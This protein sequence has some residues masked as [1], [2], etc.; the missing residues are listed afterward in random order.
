MSLCD[1][2]QF[3]RQMLEFSSNRLNTHI[4][5]FQTSLG[6]LSK[7]LY[8]RVCGF[9]RFFKFVQVI[10][11]RNPLNS[12]EIVLMLNFAMNALLSLIVKS[13]IHLTGFS[14][15]VVSSIV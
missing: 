13:A 11:Y 1:Q 4:C 14:F 3:A 2:S 10:F 5:H 7:V 8:M 9:L 12:G 6:N 15:A